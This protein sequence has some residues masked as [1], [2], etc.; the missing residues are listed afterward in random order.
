MTYQPLKESYIWEQ[1]DARAIAD[2][3]LYANKLAY[4]WF[5]F[6]HLGKKWYDGHIVNPWDKVEGDYQDKTLDRV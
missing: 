3:G 4:Y 1:P 5:Q 2:P 6:S